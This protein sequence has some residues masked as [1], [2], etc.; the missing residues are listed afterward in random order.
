MT[1]A[2]YVQDPTTQR[3]DL[4]P[5]RTLG[6]TPLSAIALP[7]GSYLLTLQVAP[8]LQIAYPVLVRRGETLALNLA[9]PTPAQI[10]EGFV[11]IPEGRFLFGCADGDLLRNFFASPP[12]HDLET[13]AFLIAKHETTYADWLDFVRTLPVEQ[14]PAF[15]PG[16]STMGAADAGIRLTADKERWRLTITAGEKTSTALEGQPLIYSERKQNA[17]QDWSRM[18]VSGIDVASAKAYMAWLDRTGRTPGARLC[19]DWEWERATRGADGR[20]FPHGEA[21]APADANS[22]ATYST[23]TEVGPDMVGLHPASRSP[24]GLEDTAGNVFE[25]V[26]SSLVP[27]EYVIRGGS[28]GYPFAIAISANRTI[29]PPELRD[30]TLGLRVCATPLR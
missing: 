25:W 22:L 21:L 18:P 11:Y 26:S 5:T 24:F 30:S 28:F 7:Q 17:Q 9:L 12:Q 2:E 6:Q 23:A 27:D 16:D 19:T 10:P 14:H 13:G 29:S 20:R 8:E 4:G 3:A 15:L 1:I